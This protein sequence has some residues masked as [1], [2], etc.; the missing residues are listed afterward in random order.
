MVLTVW[1]L[2]RE[3]WEKHIF[4]CVDMR[5]PPWPCEGGYGTNSSAAKEDPDGRRRS[6]SLTRIGRLR[7][8]ATAAQPMSLQLDGGSDSDPI[9]RMDSSHTDT[10]PASNAGADGSQMASGANAMHALQAASGP[11]RSGR[12]PG[13]AADHRETPCAAQP[14]APLS[15]LSAHRKGRRHTDDPSQ[16][17][18]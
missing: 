13:A 12:T 15:T 4:S 9:T 17:L 16:M 8:V 3:S 11:G 10:R 14:H 18:R 6:A 5:E 1:A 2:L 7:A